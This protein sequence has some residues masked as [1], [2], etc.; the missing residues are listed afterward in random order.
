MTSVLSMASAAIPSP[1]AEYNSLCA[2]IKDKVRPLGVSIGLKM[3][4]EAC[5]RS[6]TD[7]DEGMGNV[8]CV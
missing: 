7:G 1:S 4:R 5:L 2:G 3:H 6:A 8:R